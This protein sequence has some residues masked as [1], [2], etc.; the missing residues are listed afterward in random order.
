MLVNNKF[1]EADNDLYR[2]SDENNSVTVIAK[3]F[4]LLSR[5]AGSLLCMSSLSHAINNL[6]AI[7]THR[8]G[9]IVKAIHVKMSA[10]KFAFIIIG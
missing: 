3:L 2:I 9:R 1:Y 6:S 10:F 4:L 5:G 7:A 8:I